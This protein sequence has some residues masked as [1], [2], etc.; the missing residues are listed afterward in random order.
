MTPAKRTKRAGNKKNAPINSKQGNL[1]K[2]DIVSQ[3]LD[4][5]MESMVAL[6]GK[7]QDLCGY[8]DTAEEWPKDAE[9]SHVRHHTSHICR[10]WAIPQ[11]SPDPEQEVV[12]EVHKIVGKGVRQ[13][14]LSF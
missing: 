3:K 9:M 10:R 13:L 6:S 11:G 12:E 1:N 5:F 14:E 7:M 2:D 4:A 8:M